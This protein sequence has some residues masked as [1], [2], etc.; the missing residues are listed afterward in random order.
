MQFK[1][2]LLSKTAKAPVT[3]HDDDVGYDVF[4][5]FGDKDKSI[6]IFSGGRKKIPLG[7]AGSPQNGIYPHIMPRSGYALKNGI[8]ILGGV[9]D[10]GYRDELQAI[11]LNSGD[12][13]FVITHGMKVA[14]IVFL[15]VAKPD[16]VLV[17]S[18]TETTR[19]MGG[20][21][22]TGDGVITK[23]KNIHEEFLW[24]Q[25]LAPKPE[26][27]PDLTA[28]DSVVSVKDRYEHWINLGFDLT[29][30]AR[31]AS[32]PDLYPVSK[33]SQAGLTTDEGAE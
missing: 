21:G 29:E 28:G 2:K 8:Q 11:L 1:C 7:F 4:A 32:L 31:R 20:F 18:L 25:G 30:S 33:A 23:K 5:D 16:I 12:D 3:A 13:P 19:G 27:Q 26:S 6:T 17:D 24:Q 10:P 15:H 22:S 9:V 14:Q